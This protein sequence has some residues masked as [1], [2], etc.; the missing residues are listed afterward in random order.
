MKHGKSMNER[1]KL[2]RNNSEQKLWREL[3]IE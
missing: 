3:L 1:G 2:F